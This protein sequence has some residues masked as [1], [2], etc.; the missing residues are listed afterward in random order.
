MATMLA[1]LEADCNSDSIFLKRQTC[2]GVRQQTMCLGLLDLLMQRFL[3][4][5]RHSQLFGMILVAGDA[6]G[7]MFG[8]SPY[9]EAG[10][11]LAFSCGMTT[12]VCCMLPRWFNLMWFV[13]SSAHLWNS[14]ASELTFCQ[15]LLK[16]KF[17]PS[18]P[19][20]FDAPSISKAILVKDLYRH[21]FASTNTWQAW[22]LQRI[23]LP[24]FGEFHCFSLEAC[25][26]VSKSICFTTLGL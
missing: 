12:F 26:A 2:D 3:G 11:Q 19:L 7:G 5:L 14:R 13:V 15:T 1:V 6:A 22:N 18:N 17:G 8:R 20:D 23:S 4:P 16:N 9:L 10:Q 24:K 25:G 21:P